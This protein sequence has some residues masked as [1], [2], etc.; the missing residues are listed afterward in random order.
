MYQHK[1]KPAA[2]DGGERFRSPA[3]FYARSPCPTC[4]RCRADIDAGIADGS[5]NRVTLELSEIADRVAMSRRS[6]TS[7]PST[8]ATG[9]SCFDCSLEAFGLRCA[10]ELRPVERH[11]PINTII[12]THGHVPTTSWRP[13]AHH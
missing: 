8:R 2:V 7:W 11:Q 9:S 6:A 12:Y 10:S 3:A 13:A 1:Q 5:V 4:S